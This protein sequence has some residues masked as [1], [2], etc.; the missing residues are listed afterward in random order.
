MAPLGALPKSAAARKSQEQPVRRII[1]KTKEDL[2]QKVPAQAQA[3]SA[4]ASH[5]AEDITTPARDIALV[6]DEAADSGQ[7]P[8]MTAAEEDASEVAVVSAKSRQTALT[9]HL[10]RRSLPS[11]PAKSDNGEEPKAT[12]T[13]VKITRKSMPARHSSG[14]AQ[15]Q[16]QQQEEEEQLP[17]QVATTPTRTKSSARKSKVIPNSASSNS[18]DSSPISTRNRTASI[19]GSSAAGYGIAQA[20][21]DDGNNFG[22]DVPASATAEAAPAHAMDATAESK[23]VADRVGE[24]VKVAVEQALSH[25]RYPTAWALRSLYDDSVAMPHVM[26]LF[27][28]VFNQKASEDMLAEFCLMV[29]Q[30]KREGK[31]DNKACYA[32][33]PPSTNSR[34]PPHQPKPAPYGDM[35]KLDLAKIAPRLATPPPPE[36]PSAAS[37]EPSVPDPDAHK[38][39]RQKI[40]GRG[41]QQK[42]PTKTRSSAAPGSGANGTKT[43]GSRRGK[44]VGSIDSTSSLSSAPSDLEEVEEEVFGSDAPAPSSPTPMPEEQQ[45]G[46]GG[47]APANHDQQTQVQK[48]RWE[49]HDSNPADTPDQPE[50]RMP[51]VATKATAAKTTALKNREPPATAPRRGTRNN[52]DAASNGNGANND[53]NNNN[54]VAATAADSSKVSSPQPPQ[55]APP[56]FASKRGA[57]D[58]DDPKVKLRRDARKVTNGI[59]ILESFSRGGDSASIESA[60]EP[61]PTPAP[62]LAPDASGSLV[63]DVSTPTPSSGQQ[64]RRPRAAHQLRATRSAR[65]R[66]HEEADDDTPPPLSTSF[67]PP[68]V[69]TPSSTVNSRAGTPGP[70]PAK[71]ARTGLRVKNSPMK[72]RTGPSAGLPRASGERSSPAPA[73]APNSL[74]DND[75]YCASCSGNGELVC[76]E[77]CSRSFHFKCVDPPLQAPNLPEEWF[78]NVCLSE[79]NPASMLHRSGSFQ[80]LITDLN[81]KNSSAFR[82]PADVRDYFVDVRAGPDG[83]YEDV[84]PA[85]PKIK[86]RGGYEEAPDFFRVRDGDGNAVVC[87]YCDSPS[88]AN[89]AIIPCNTCSLFWHLDCLDP[90]LAV[91]PVLR[92]WRCPAH[93]DDLLAVMPATL[94]PAHKRRRVKGAS[95]IRPAYSRGLKNNGY[96]EIEDDD[97]DDA[98]ASNMLVSADQRLPAR[99]L[100]LDFVDSVRSSSKHRDRKRGRKAIAPERGSSPTVEGVFCDH[101]HPAPA[102]GRHFDPRPIEHVQAAHSLSSLA[103]AAVGPSDSVGLLIDAMLAGADDNVI[104]LMSRTNPIHLE[105]GHGLTTLDKVGL[106]AMLARLTQLTGRVE[107][108]IG[109]PDSV[110]SSPPTLIADRANLDEPSFIVTAD[111]PAAVPQLTEGTEKSTPEVEELPVVT[112]VT[113]PEPTSP[114]KQDLGCDDVDMADSMATG[115]D[116]TETITP[117]KAMTT[118]RVAA[119][120]NKPDVPSTM[121]GG[122]ILSS[123]GDSM[124]TPSTSPAEDNARIIKDGGSTSKPDVDGM[125]IGINNC[126]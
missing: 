88:A 70:R 57:L 37:P 104:S 118:P 17:R 27:D 103:N 53:N 93:V 97:Y 78:C 89:R 47:G 64:L 124:L 14:G 109:A 74:D 112:P 3:A 73:G 66:S 71:K 99:G 1:L 16:Q 58:E 87:H 81:M 68:V 51:A 95:A 114:V 75:D 18:S 15:H 111:S 108:L 12:S 49:L 40:V 4:S 115:P 106:K 19:S 125:G 101:A 50:V 61:S 119:F 33:V 105:Q 79:R 54:G 85:A 24:V 94:A 92:T 83:E 43:P 10:T 55:S 41:A 67:P 11:A 20:D 126:P 2:D 72:K 107:Q 38:T 7:E 26:E 21:G 52:R 9:P 29:K 48:D 102:S 39:K 31:K 117:V 28:Q 76:C 32:L 13:R 5:A 80:Y 77:T 35:I 96:I 8:T 123:F 113:E 121:A 100:V 59:T 110:P 42:T 30:K 69:P 90:P 91:P 25:F 56:K 122:G 120:A 98:Q 45:Q 62:T 6:S 116:D 23:E 22:D 86:R 84:P 65:K 60:K 63:A 44:R 82:L 36:A 46:T 34:P